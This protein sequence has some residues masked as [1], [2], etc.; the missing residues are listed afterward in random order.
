MP[1]YREAGFKAIIMEWD[2]PA[3]ANP[4]WN[5][6]WR[7]FPQ[8]AVGADGVPFPLI[9]NKSVAFQKVQRFV[10]GEIEIDEYLEYVNSHQGKT[11]RAFPIYGNDV[12]VFD[13]RP[14][15][16][17][18]EA[19]LE[20]E[21]EWAKL[22]SLYLALQDTS[23]VEFVS[24]SQVLNMLNEEGAGNA[25][26]LETTEYPVP[27]KKQEKYNVLRWAVSG[28][29]DLGINT[30]CWQIYERLRE[31]QEITEEDWAELCYL[32]SSDFRTHITEQ[33]WSDYLTQL[34]GMLKRCS[35][36]LPAETARSVE[37]RPAARLSKSDQL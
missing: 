13:F 6:D 3:R 11:V 30:K 28:R 34:N 18:T 16:C 27:V 31:S 25:L 2:N 23:G 29:D 15:R 10:H 21:S 37:T 20:S 26:R 32:W 9:W 17:M 12:E 36:R 24:P 35:V 4:E 5:A 7:Y 1:L 33:R 8:Y 14:G 22:E 19:P